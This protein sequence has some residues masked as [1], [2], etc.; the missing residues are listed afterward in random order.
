M[1]TLSHIHDRVLLEIRQWK[2]V[3]AII[4]ENWIAFIKGRQVSSRVLITDEDVDEAKWKKK[5][6]CVLRL[7]LRKHFT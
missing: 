4:F 6:S 5:E 3:S 7:I 2:V 1:R